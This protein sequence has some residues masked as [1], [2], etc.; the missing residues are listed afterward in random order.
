MIHGVYK[1]YILLFTC[2]V[3][4]AVN[5]EITTDLGNDSLI[6]ALRRFLAK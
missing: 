4:K 2:G 3:T 1:A 6:L 5:L